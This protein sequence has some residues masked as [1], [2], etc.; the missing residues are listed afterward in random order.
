MIKCTNCGYVNVDK[1]QT[2]ANCGEKLGE[3]P[4][5]E[6]RIESGLREAIKKRNFIIIG[7][8]ALCIILLFALLVKFTSRDNPELKSAYSQIRELE[9]QV[10]SVQ[11]EYDSYKESMEQ[12][13]DVFPYAEDIKNY[14]TLKS[15]IEKLEQE[16]EETEAGVIEL[17]AE[18]EKLE[19]EIESAKNPTATSDYLLY[20]DDKVEIYFSGITR[21]GVVF[22]VKNM[23]DINLTFQADSIAING[24]STNDIVM[25]DSVTQQSVGKIVARCSDFEDTENVYSV[26]GQ[27]TAI[28]FSS[29]NW[30]SYK[31]KFTNVENN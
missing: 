17:K 18:Y 4:T 2:C 13:E 21:E 5:T 31:I 30:D 23:T 6:N 20:S 7:L 27:L 3:V 22:E 10:A 8:G 15:E 11:S 19:K 28:D 14:G 25:S 16:K 9:N 24:V 26:S 1:A 12:Y 29:R